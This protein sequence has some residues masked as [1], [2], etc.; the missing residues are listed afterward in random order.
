LTGLPGAGVASLPRSSRNDDA[1]A[2]RIDYGLVSFLLASDITAATEA[3]LLDAGAPLRATVLKVA[4]H[5]SRGSS[6]PEFLRAVSPRVAVISVGPRNPYG[7]P[8]PETLAR[9]DT[10][11]AAVY[12]TDRDGAVILETDGRTL[13]VT[14]WAADRTTHYCHDPA[15]TC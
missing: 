6:T 15:A 8:S 13:T 5:G 14:A 12:R 11:G 1:L 7:H 10:V 4:H 3:S 2:L 9:L